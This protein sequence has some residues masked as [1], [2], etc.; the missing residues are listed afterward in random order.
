MK[1][2]ERFGDFFFPI[3]DRIISGQLGLYEKAK[4]KELW[5]KSDK[6]EVMGNIDLLRCVSNHPINHVLSHTLQ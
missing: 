1:E 3:G 4:V 2:Q 5:G 6:R